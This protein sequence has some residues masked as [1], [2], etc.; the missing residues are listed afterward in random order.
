MP[1]IN[2]DWAAPQLAVVT[3]GA[4]VP[5]YFALPLVQ[6]PDVR[7]EH[8]IVVRGARER[9]REAEDTDTKSNDCWVR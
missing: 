6:E 9:P 1:A 4:T 8:E 5:G 7:G 2:P 3:L